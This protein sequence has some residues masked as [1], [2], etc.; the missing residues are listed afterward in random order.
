MHHGACAST[1][2]GSAYFANYFCTYSY[3]YHQKEMLEDR[4]RTTAYYNACLQ[5]K[6]N[7]HDKASTFCNSGILAIFAAKAGARK[8]YAVE[9]TSMAKFAKRM[10][11]AQGLEGVVEV[12]QGV[13]ESVT[14]PE[15]VDIIISEWMGD[16]EQF[17]GVSMDC[18]SSDFRREQQEYLQATAAWTDESGP[19]E[20][21]CGFFDTTF[22]G[23]KADPTDFPVTLST[24]PDP[25][26]ATHWGQ[27]Y[28]LLRESMLD[29]VLVA[30]DK[31]LKPGGALFPSHA[32]M[33][34][35]P[36]RSSLTHQRQ[37]EFQRCMEDWADFLQSFLLHPP[38]ECAA[39]DSLKC[40]IEVSRRADNQRLMDVRFRHRLVGPSPAALAAGERVSAFRIE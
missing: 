27:G 1:H 7:F 29:S 18:L 2:A 34:V 15:K 39:G 10:V 14:L 36:I 11:A 35:A 38:V 3:L 5:N 37:A 31:F 30:R 4:V 16:M 40:E 21:F 20:A 23:S 19:V 32:R 13:V 6:R 22:A 26:G 12:I 33:F 25:T 8:V 17:Y 28:F 9:A 24:A